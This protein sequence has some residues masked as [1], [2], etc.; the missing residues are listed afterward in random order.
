[1]YTPLLTLL[2]ILAALQY[3]LVILDTGV[4]FITLL[5]HEVFFISVTFVSITLTGGHCL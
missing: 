1:M 3:S 2:R 4:A 5:T